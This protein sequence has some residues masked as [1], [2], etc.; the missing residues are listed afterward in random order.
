MNNEQAADPCTRETE[1]SPPQQI[2]DIK[3]LEASSLHPGTVY[4]SDHSGHSATTNES[5]RNAAA[6]R[7]EGNSS[8]DTAEVASSLIQDTAESSTSKL[9]S[10]SS[11]SAEQLRSLISSQ[12]SRESEIRIIAILLR[13]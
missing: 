12:N 6:Q 13:T 10:L 2:K 3:H 7:V 4:V 8:L 9:F 5:S 1:S 11:F